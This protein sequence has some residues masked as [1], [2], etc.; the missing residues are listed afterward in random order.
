[1]PKFKRVF[2]LYL[3]KFYKLQLWIFFLTCLHY[4]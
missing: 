3:R 4:L 2:L 1:M